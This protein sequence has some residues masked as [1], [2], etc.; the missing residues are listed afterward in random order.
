M[1]VEDGGNAH[2]G[3]LLFSLLKVGPIVK[4]KPEGTAVNTM[5]PIKAELWLSSKIAAEDFLY[6]DDLSA[7]ISAI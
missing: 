2:P 7:L 6:A 1:A 5:D 3:H 4:S